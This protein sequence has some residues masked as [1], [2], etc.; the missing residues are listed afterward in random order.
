MNILPFFLFVFFAAG[1]SFTIDKAESIITVSRTTIVSGLSVVSTFKLSCPKHKQKE[2]T[3]N[4]RS[5]S[6]IAFY[7]QSPYGQELRSNF[8]MMKK[9]IPLS[10]YVSMGLTYYFLANAGGV[11]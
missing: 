1:L 9:I 3:M 5:A 2:E 8:L 11:G 10:V 7:Q 6:L 4:M